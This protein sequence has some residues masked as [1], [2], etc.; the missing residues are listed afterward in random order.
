[1]QIALDFAEEKFGIANTQESDPIVHAN[2][3]KGFVN[4]PNH[5]PKTRLKIRIGH[6]TYKYYSVEEIISDVPHKPRLVMIL[7]SQFQ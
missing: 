2:F 4:K 3:S 6:Q 5:L 1:M 7:H